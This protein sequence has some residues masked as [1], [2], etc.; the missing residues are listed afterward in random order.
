MSV[1]LSSY[2]GGIQQY[3]KDNFGI[4]GSAANDYQGT[5]QPDPAAAYDGK[6]SGNAY[7]GGTNGS[8]YAGWVGTNPISGNNAFTGNTGSLGYGP[9]NPIGYNP[10]M[11]MMNGGQG[12]AAYGGSGGGDAP[13]QMTPQQPQDTG[14]GT[15]TSWQG[16]SPVGAGGGQ[17]FGGGQFDDISGAP[18]QGPLTPSVSGTGN[19]GQN[20]GQ[21]ASGS[22]ERD[23]NGQ[24]DWDQLWSP[25]MRNV[26]TSNPQFDPSR[27]SI[28]PFSTMPSW[29]G[30]QDPNGSQG[31]QNYPNSIQAGQIGAIMDQ[32]PAQPWNDG[33][34]IFEGQ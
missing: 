19:P 2:P 1:D 15:G 30:G 17:K 23:V 16:I 5:S 12:G 26:D 7:A 4:Q 33:M 34:N 9:N 24:S 27:P 18:T 10:Q 8:S 20:Q 13:G 21:S 3:L 25:Q 22:T 28:P 6:T 11:A 31:G 32:I 14:N 29:N